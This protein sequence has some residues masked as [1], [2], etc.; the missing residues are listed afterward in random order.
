MKKVIL[1]GGILVAIVAGMLIA[2]VFCGACGSQSSCPAASA[3]A[4]KISAVAYHEGEA[5]VVQMKVAQVIGSEKKSEKLKEAV[6]KVDGVEKVSACLESGTV[7]IRFDHVKTGGVDPVTAAVKKAGFKY[8]MA[9]GSCCSK[10]KAK[11]GD[12][13]C[14][15][16]KSS[17]AGK[18]KEI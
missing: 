13:S 18:D 6:M 5:S 2:R 14:A 4:E 7:T 17:C 16:Q 9:G 11:A 1:I 3:S 8:E 12:K 15:P 10:G